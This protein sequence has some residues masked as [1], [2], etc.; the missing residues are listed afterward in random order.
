V[1]QRIFIRYPN[2]KLYDAA[3]SCYVSAAAVLDMI[4]GGVDVKI[5]DKANMVDVTGAV[6]IKAVVD[7]NI[8]QFYTDESVHLLM[9]IIREGGFAEYSKKLL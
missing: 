8:S 3:N 6:L 1:N 4:R 5:V 7:E 2:R 9:K